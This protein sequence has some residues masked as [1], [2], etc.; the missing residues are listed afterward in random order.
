M[1]AYR[2][3]A[4]VAVV[5]A[6]IGGAGWS[7]RR[8]EVPPAAGAPGS[9]VV[10]LVNDA[11]I[12][13][14]DLDVRLDEILPSASYHGRVDAN[15]LLSLRR[16]ALD[17][18]VLDE[19]I[20]R[21]AVA[22]GQSAPRAAVDAEVAAVRAR[23]ETADLFA[24]A[25]REYGM[26]EAQLR[27]RATRTVLVR[28]QRAARTRQAIGRT[29][30]EAYYRDN[31]ATFQRPE[32]AHLLEILIRADPADKASS[33]AAARKARTILGRLR[34]GEAFAPI[35]RALSEDEYRVKDG[36]MGLVHRG[37]L[38]PAFDAA[39]FA[40]P[41]GRFAIAESLYGYQVFMVLERRPA[42]QLSLQEARPI[43]A[44]RLERRRREEARRAWRAQL[45]SAARVTIFDPALRNAR[46]AD[47]G[48]AQTTLASRMRAGTQPGSGQ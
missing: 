1:R 4:V 36:D 19:L 16:A 30:I 21:E 2:P 15:R 34:R 3:L 18:L 39:V 46:P 41:P 35:A 12:T 28:E 5:A 32:Q 25:L 42:T 6:V 10:A 27:A 20:Y 47:L 11:P 40:A 38:D 7:M 13:A 31:A 37:R 17:E 22:V 44:A 8:F 24:A 9:S 14:D 33:R 26:S 48:A 43:I 29:D 23:F 45:L